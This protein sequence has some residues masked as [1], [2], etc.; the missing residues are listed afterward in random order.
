VHGPIKWA[1]AVVAITGASR[2]IGRAIAK[3][4]AARGARVGLVARSKPDLDRVLAEIGG[5]GAIA[6]AEVS[7]R[8]AITGALAAI[9]RELGPIEVLVNNAGIGAFGAFET[10]DVETF[11]RMMR[12]NYL[13]TLYA[14]KAALPT[15]LER[16]RG[17]IVNV[18]SV[19][20]RI[21][22]PLE[23]AYSA[24]KFAVAGLSE[25]VALEVEGRGVAISMVHPGP[26]ETEFFETRGHPYELSSPRPISAE[27]VA[28]A[29]IAAVERN[30]AE[31]F[32]PRWL[33]SAYAARVMFPPL[34]RSGTRRRF[35]ELL[36]KGT[37][38]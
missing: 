38:S 17:H 29:V 37:T 5:A 15:M 33:G 32:L 35:R 30:V 23:S 21:G 36:P 16:R 27:R 8:E 14:M 28:D 7:D 1:G 19:A 10:T 13:G 18:V 2:G 34:Y 3:A 31:Q 22:A 4:A 25:A 24:S 9:A 20:G 12:V 26:V 6:V 11:E